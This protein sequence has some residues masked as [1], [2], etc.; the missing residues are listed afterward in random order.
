[1]FDTAD[2][3]SLAI[4]NSEMTEARTDPSSG[5]GRYSKLFAFGGPGQGA[6]DGADP[7]AQSLI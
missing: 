5:T 2:L 4:D 1:M 7:W 6:Q 3:D